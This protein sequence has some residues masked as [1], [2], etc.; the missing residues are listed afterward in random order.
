MVHNTKVV[1][2]LVCVFKIIIKGVPNSQIIL[3][4]VFGTFIRNECVCSEIS[5]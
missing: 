4:G 5:L 2:L 1:C 3:T